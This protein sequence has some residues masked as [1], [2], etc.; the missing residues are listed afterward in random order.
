MMDWLEAALQASGRQA[1]AA[2]PETLTA[3][4]HVITIPDVPP[5]EWFAEPTDVPMDA[6]LTVTDEGRVY[7]WLAPAG[8]AHRSFQRRVTVPM[9]NVDYSKYLGRETI[10]AG[11]ER[12]VTGALTMDCGHAG[13][14]MSTGMS[15]DHYDNACSVVAAV[16]IGE[17][18]GGVWVAGALLP[19]VSA[20]QISRMMM[21]ALSGDW[22]P[23]RERSGWREFAGALLVPVPGF[24][25]ARR[26]P[27]VRVDQDGTLVACAVPVLYASSDCGCDS[28]PAIPVPPVEDEAPAVPQPDLSVVCQ[29]IAE[30]IGLDF[31]SQTEMIRRSVEI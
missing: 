15:L 5:A 11:G 12:I 2:E 14:D 31:T 7:G 23:H 26:A 28:E 9:G 19:G 4:A 10:V 29:L 8:V 18:R 25:M 17:N 20:S 24:A 16:R 30:R 27:S 1:P 22:R 21:C 6:A 13:H 3:A